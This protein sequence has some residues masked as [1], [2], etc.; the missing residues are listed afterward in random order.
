META[1]IKNIRQKRDVLMKSIKQVN[2]ARF[3][4]QSFGNESEYNYRGIIAGIDSMLTDITT[5]TKATRKFI[6]IST[7]R[8]RND[9][10]SHL[11]QINTYL[12]Q[13]SQ[14]S[15]INPFEALKKL[16][17]ELG[18]RSFSERQ[19]EFENEIENVTRLKVKVD[20]ELKEINQLRDKIESNEELIKDK[21][22]KQKEKLETIN[23]G[24]ASLEERKS[25]LKASATKFE[26]LL[27]NL[28]EKEKSSEKYLE[29]IE[30]SL[31]D[32]KSNE[33]LINQFSQTVERRDKQLEKLESRMNDNDK[34][35]EDYDLERKKILNESK[36]L[37]A[38]A[39]KALNYKTA[40]G[41]SAAF[42]EQYDLASDK[43]LTSFWLYVAGASMILAIGL[44]IWV[45]ATGGEINYIIGRISL[46]PLALLVAFFAGKQYVRQK[47]IAE[48]YAYKMVLSK[49]IVGFSEQI[50]KHGNENNEEYVH[51]IKRALEEI[52]KDPLRNRS[53]KTQK[54]EKSNL[55]DIIDMAERIVALTKTNN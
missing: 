19:L 50:K 26:S 12:S 28:E 4:D 24:I 44:G 2:K 29:E 45:L 31:T 27:G 46:I 52:H 54:N 15:F 21:Y 37:I 17:R 13:P 43:K 7:H 48:D 11:N 41:I 36:D 8:E 51:Y 3:K 55:Q 9:I 40:E 33:K 53:L 1:S 25:E 23:E 22:E 34:L 42:Q 5:L 32:S 20:E 6:K 39:K 47:N 10:A 49:A 30:K 14:P 38:S 35:L 18:V 16:L